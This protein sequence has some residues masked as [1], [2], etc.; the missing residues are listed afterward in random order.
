MIRLIGEYTVWGKGVKYW[1][2]LVWKSCQG[3]QKENRKLEGLSKEGSKGYDKQG[4]NKFGD[5]FESPLTC[6]AKSHS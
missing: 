5:F 1:W 3:G 2:M 6:I 4:R